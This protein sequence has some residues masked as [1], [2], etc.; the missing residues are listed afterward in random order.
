MSDPIQQEDDLL[1]RIA[2]AVE[3]KLA[4]V[5]QIP[6]THP[7]LKG[8]FPDNL[9]DDAT[10]KFGPCFDNLSSRDMIECRKH[11]HPHNGS[12]FQDAQQHIPKRAERDLASPG[13]ATQQNVS[14]T[15][16]V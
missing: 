14:V 4:Q 7:A 5:R 11:R 10:F 15:D 2:R 12:V 9:D 13:D 16:A 6:T 8:C 1:L 3:F